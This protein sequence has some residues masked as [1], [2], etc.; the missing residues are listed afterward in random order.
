MHVE[1]G[2]GVGGDLVGSDSD[3]RTELLA[4]A[5]LILVDVRERHQARSKGSCCLGYQE[6]D[7]PRTGDED[8]GARRDACFAAR[9][10]G[11]RER[12]DER[13]RFGRDG[14]RESEGEVFADCNLALQGSVDR[15]GRMED[16]LRAEVVA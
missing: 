16:H 8:P 9:P 15:W 4:E 2:P 12:L 11:H 7:W 10:Y 6:T 14:I 3:V 5:E 13:T 1:L